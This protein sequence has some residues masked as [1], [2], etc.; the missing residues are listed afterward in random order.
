MSLTVR[1]N[2]ELPE[3]VVMLATAH[4][5][6]FPDTITPAIGKAPEM[7]EALAELMGKSERR[8]VLSPDAGSVKSYIENAVLR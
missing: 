6:K 2:Q 7:P 1:T 3:P 5:G 8:V 4:P